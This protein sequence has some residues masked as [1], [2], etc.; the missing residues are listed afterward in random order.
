MSQ[1][2]TVEFEVN[3]PAVRDALLD[4]CASVIKLEKRDRGEST[5]RVFSFEAERS[6]RRIALAIGFEEQLEAGYRVA[7]LPVEVADRLATSVA[8]AIAEEMTALVC[9]ADELQ[10]RGLVVRRAA[11]L[12]QTLVALDGAIERLTPR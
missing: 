9:D 1:Y 8:V 11:R 10:P 12:M 4:G 5:D 6:E 3:S 7:D 2:M